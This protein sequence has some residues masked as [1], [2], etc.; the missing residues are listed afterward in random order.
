MNY[1]LNRY[2]RKL[3]AKSHTRDMKLKYP[4][5]IKFSVTNSVIQPSDVNTMVTSKGY[6]TKVTLIRGTSEDSII[7]DCGV[8]NFASYHNAGGKFLSGSS[9]QEESLCHRS[10]LF[11]VLN[12]E[13]FNDEFYSKH[14]TNKGLYDSDLIISPKIIFDNSKSCTV[15][16]CAAVNAKVAKGYGVSDTVI[17]Y[18]MRDRI[19]KILYAFNQVGCKV[20][21]LGAFGCG[22]FENNCHMVASIFRDLLESEY[23]GCFKEVIFTI[24]DSKNYDIFENVFSE[25]LK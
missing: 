25:V 7:E 5:E 15:V 13:R 23:A 8:L 18:T 20:L 19:D 1:W 3:K 14:D 2:E 22:V 24:P 10:F 21:I 12:N 4:N 9:A 6:N 17:Y 11:N 16:T